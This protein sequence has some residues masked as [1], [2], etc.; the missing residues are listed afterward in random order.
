MS[1]DTTGSSAFLPSFWTSASSSSSPF[2]FVVSQDL[3]QDNLTS[4]RSLVT[5]RFWR[6]WSWTV[7]IIILEAYL[8][9]R[10]CEKGWQ[11]VQA[12]TFTKWGFL[13]QVVKYI[14]TLED[15]YDTEYAF[16]QSSDLE[17]IFL[18]SPLEEMHSNNNKNNKHFF[19]SILLDW[20][21]KLIIVI[22]MTGIP[23]NK[24]QT[25]TTAVSLNE[26]K[27]SVWQKA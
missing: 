22:Y 14:V 19:P 1:F 5:V 10:N 23:Q 24:K 13:S 2:S 21:F 3:N 9:G 25:R 12:S 6:S 17:D 11:L 18:F 16:W 26:K 20:V 4:Q 15:Q 8:E 7:E 27:Q